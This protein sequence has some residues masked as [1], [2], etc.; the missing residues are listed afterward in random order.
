LGGC[1]CVAAAPGKLDAELRRAGSS[2]RATSEPDLDAP[3][4]GK[5]W[6]IKVEVVEAVLVLLRVGAARIGAGAAVRIGGNQPVRHVSIAGADFISV[7]VACLGDFGS[8][9]RGCE[10][11]RA[12]HTPGR[13][14]GGMSGGGAQGCIGRSRRTGERRSRSESGAQGCIGRRGGWGR[15]RYQRDRVRLGIETGLV[16][17]VAAVGGGEG[18]VPDCCEHD[19]A[20]ACAS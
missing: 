14:R 8:I 16:G 1:P 17:G 6:D 5:G 2:C 15:R 12:A 7:V 13:I 4:R 11:A 18:L 3:Q 19:V 20:A 9:G 10:K